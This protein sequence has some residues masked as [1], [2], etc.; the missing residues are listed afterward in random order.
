MDEK[1][2]RPGCR[3]A[4]PRLARSIG[5]AGVFTLLWLAGARAARAQAAAPPAPC[6]SD[7]AYAT[8]DFWL[9]SWRVYADTALAGTNR[10][11]KILGGCAVREEWTDAQGGRGESL[12]YYH[13]AER[14]WKQV[15]VTEQAQLVGGLK[16]KHLVG[17]LPGGGLRFAG[18][19]VLPDGRRIQD[20]T[21]LTPEPG[22]EVRQLIEI[23]RDG[24]GTWQTTFDA[25]YRRAPG[26]RP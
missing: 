26:S 12:F 11:T 10:I 15:W 18:E 17:R 5:S 16:E 25:R 9:G 23:S 8:L 6:A 7:S 24:G 14:T 4:C 21:T 19:L 22:G 20:R 2:P 3:G 13:R 1:S